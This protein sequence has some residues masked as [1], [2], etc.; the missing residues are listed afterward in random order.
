MGKFIEF[1]HNP[2]KIKQWISPSKFINY[3]VQKA[4]SL[5]LFEIDKKFWI[6]KGI[7]KG[8]YYPY[9]TDPLSLLIGKFL[10]RL[11]SRTFEK[12]QVSRNQNY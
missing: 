5:N 9:I 3:N 2:E 11:L 12:N 7:D 6:E 1:I 8:Y 4:V 10:F